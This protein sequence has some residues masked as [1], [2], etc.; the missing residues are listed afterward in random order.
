MYTVI[1]ASKSVMESIEKYR[2]F[3]APLLQSEEI[4][5]C[6][7]NR[8]ADTFE[9]MLPDLYE[10]IANHSKWRAV[11]LDTGRENHKNPF[12]YLE[13]VDEE[14]SSQPID[15][16]GFSRRQKARF[17]N[18]EEAR[19][20]PLTCLSNGL[21]SFSVP[22]SVADSDLFSRILDDDMDLSEFMLFRYLKSL[23]LEK[24]LRYW[25]HQDDFRLKKLL[26]VE[27][28]T[29][30]FGYIE[31]L[32][33]ASVRKC[34]VPDKMVELIRLFS[35]GDPGFIDPTYA[36]SLLAEN[37]K[38]KILS[39][40]YSRYECKAR[41]PEHVY[42]VSMRA[43]AN[44]VGSTYEPASVFDEY[45]YSRFAEFNLYPD[46]LYYLLFNASTP[47]YQHYEQD[48]I[49]YL[50]FI[51][52]IS[53][54]DLP[55]D[56]I[57][58]NRVY[59]GDLELDQEDF[60]DVCRRYYLKLEST[61]RDI[62]NKLSRLEESVCEEISNEDA[63]KEFE[64]PV[65]IS[66]ISNSKISNADLMAPLHPTGLA[67][68]CPEDELHRWRLSYHSIHKNFTKYLREPRRAVKTAV[69]G[70]FREKNSLKSGNVFRLGDFQIEN[71]E[72]ILQ[73]EERNM[74]NTS[75]AFLYNTEV[76]QQRLE[77]AK[78]EVCDVMEKRMERRSVILLGVSALV[79]FILGFIPMFFSQLNADESLGISFILFGSALFVLIIVALITLFVLRNRV[80]KALK[81][82][83]KVMG[84]ICEEIHKGMQAFA[85]Y[86]GHACN[87]MRKFDV[88][89]AIEHK[90][91]YVPTQ[92]K[93]LKKHLY[94][95]ESHI[96]NMRSYFADYLEYV[97]YV[98]DE[99]TSFEYDFDMLADY[100]FSI[101]YPDIEAEIE[102][103]QAG[104]YIKIPV[105]YVHSVTMT[106]EELYD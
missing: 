104:N 4:S 13:Y 79:L 45:R 14:I 83:N 87:V 82:F 6:E 68:N 106:R 31:N 50:T 53:A 62:R 7:W 99:E 10:K 91:E 69:A 64:A 76:Y 28:L 54:N 32:D 70:E 38:V 63:E 81:Q 93:I 44:G 40:I 47:E 39:D 55:K 33:T 23:P 41:K 9:G 65:G 16:E 42:C 26:G 46:H 24:M 11:I 51:L 12:D 75:T 101:T 90:N 67:G 80:I 36:D 84:D 85:K 8:Y 49:R 94:D 52:L 22:A 35:E 17:A 77:D 58:R 88:L 95:V 37:Q 1:I 29:E 56:S 21:T 98:P 78:E 34:L 74:V 92:C 71:I 5:F 3:L 72:Y 89:N 86:L 61:A 103:I 19:N 48:Y 15:W 60:S 59:C 2:L 73:E 43:A 20:N 25:R 100:D 66:V 102:F 18:F 57:K 97:K 27:D 96:S 105:D 30:F